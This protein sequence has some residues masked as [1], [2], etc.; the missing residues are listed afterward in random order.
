MPLDPG[1]PHDRIS[2]IEKDAEFKVLL[3][4]DESVLETQRPPLGC[5]IM[6]VAALL[7]ANKSQEGPSGTRDPAGPHTMAYII[8]TSGKMAAVRGTLLT[9]FRMKLT[10]RLSPRIHGQAQGCGC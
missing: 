10:L 9:L 7:E 2:L 8:Y 6:S 3:V 5:P 4:K 1:Y